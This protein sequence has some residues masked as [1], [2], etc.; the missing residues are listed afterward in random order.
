MNITPQNIS[1][2]VVGEGCFY[3]ESGKDPDYKL[4]YRIRAGFEIEVAEEDKEILESIQKQLGCGSVYHVDFGR[5][6]EYSR[7]KWKRHVKYRVSNQQDI[8]EKVIVF[9]RQYPLFGKKQKVF[10]VFC[11]IVKRLQNKD[12]LSPERLE[13]LK[14]LVEKLKALN[15]RGK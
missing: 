1:G 10:E 11:E 15:K 5:Y 2:F 13:E 9:F 12:H 4:G 14:A 8:A 3:V 7:K 6:K